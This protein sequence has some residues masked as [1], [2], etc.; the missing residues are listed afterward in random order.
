[1]F[2]GYSTVSSTEGNFLRSLESQRTP[3]HHMSQGRSTPC[4]GDGK[5][6]TFN[7]ESLF[8]G[9]INPYYWV[10][11]HP[12]LYANNVSLDPS[13]YVQQQI[14]ST[15]H[16]SSTSVCW[17][18]IHP[19]RGEDLQQIH[20]IKSISKNF[21]P[22]TARKKT[23]ILRSTYIIG[24]YDIYHIRV[25]NSATFSGGTT[26]DGWNPAPGEVGSLSHYL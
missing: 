20:L 1:M 22:T 14:P 8:H 12:V 21:F 17:S 2:R 4:I 25:L 15:P 26:V 11:D 19:Q 16:L 5:P 23:V 18:F 13:T 24:Y 9:Y 7:R 6:P 10:D 3:S